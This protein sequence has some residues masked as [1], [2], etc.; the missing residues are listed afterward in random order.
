MF[1]M[2]LPNPKDGDTPLHLCKT[3]ALATLLLRGGPKGGANPHRGRNKLGK[4]AYEV[5][6]QELRE[7]IDNYRF[8]CGQFEMSALD[9]PEHA[10]ATSVV[11]RA[12]DKR[13]GEDD[14]TIAEVV[15][16][17]MKHENQFNNEQQHK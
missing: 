5:Q 4:T 11:I 3:P 2:T 7:L 1:N 17:L 12:I 10:T 6:T 8:F 9:T 14:G 15:L 16:K 13:A